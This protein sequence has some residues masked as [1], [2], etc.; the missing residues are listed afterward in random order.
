MGRTT[1]TRDV[2]SGSTNGRRI[3]VAATAT[4]GTTIHTATAATGALDFVTLYAQN[5]HTA[6]LLLTIEWG[7]TTS[8]DDLIQQTIVARSGDT[9][10][11]AGL[12]LRGGLVIKAFCAS[13]NLVT[14]SG[15]IERGVEE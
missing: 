6:D 2:L 10:I 11:V 9:L 3:K 14:I 4:P 13:A 7:G 15:F 1:V 8:P 12:P 5:A